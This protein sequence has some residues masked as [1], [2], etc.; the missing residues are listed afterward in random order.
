MNKVYYH[1]LNKTAKEDQI[2]QIENKPEKRRHVGNK[3]SV[4]SMN[5]SSAGNNFSSV[6]RNSESTDLDLRQS[7]ETTALELQ[8][9]FKSVT[10][11]TYRSKL[12]STLQGSS[13]T[14]DAGWGCML[15]TG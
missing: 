8:S 6:A 15:R 11:F 4:T 12:E 9:A 2:D 14:G 3:M 1:S 10:W 7:L 5:S 13:Y